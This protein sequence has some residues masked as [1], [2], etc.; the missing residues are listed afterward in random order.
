MNLVIS[1]MLQGS[2][3]FVQASMDTM[4]ERERVLLFFHPLIS[5]SSLSFFAPLPSVPSGRHAVHSAWNTSVLAS[6]RT[7]IVS[8]AW[9]NRDIKRQ[10][11]QLFTPCW[12]GHGH[13]A[14]HTIMWLSILTSW[15][16]ITMHLVPRKHF[17]KMF[18]K[19]WS[20]RFRIYRKYWRD[21]SSLLI[22]VSGSWTQY[23]KK[24]VSHD[25]YLYSGLG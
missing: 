2:I 10:S 4:Q 14:P 17:S 12:V 15:K 25:S 16:Y 24:H 5:P 3:F 11:L 7:S 19:F 6:Y 22:V 18:S 20:V 21:I 1:I 23:L 8:G 13:V 9:D